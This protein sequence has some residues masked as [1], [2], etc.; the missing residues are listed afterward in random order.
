MRTPGGITGPESQSSFILVSQL[1]FAGSVE[2]QPPA[3]NSTTDPSRCLHLKAKFIKV[4]SLLSC[5][6]PEA[7][8][9][10]TPFSDLADD[11]NHAASQTTF[12]TNQVTDIAAPQLDPKAEAADRPFPNGGIVVLRK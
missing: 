11:D 6:A 5:S 12:P 8:G 7:F 1:V 3:E 9:F 4:P 10:L 2:L